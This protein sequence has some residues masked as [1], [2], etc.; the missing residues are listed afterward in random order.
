MRL[1]PAAR[2]LAVALLLP[3]LARPAAA[4]SYQGERDLGQRFDLAA[5][6]SVPLI[7][8]P[9]VIAYVTRIGQSVARTLTPSFFEYQF[10]VVRDPRI[11]AFAVP[12]GWVY[13]HA[14]LLAAVRSDDELAGVLGHEI[15]HVHNRHVVRQQEQTAALNYTAMLGMLLGVIQPAAGALTTAASQAAALQYQRD[16]EQ[17]ADYFGA[18]HVQEA[19]YDPRAMLDFFQQLA[20]QQRLSPT[21]APAYLQTHPLSDERLNRLE[22]VLKTSP[23]KRRQRPPASFDL[24]RVQALVRA[25]IEPAADVLAAY[26]RAL[27]QHPHDPTAQYLYGVVCLESGELD[28][29]QRSLSAARAGGLAAADRELG[30]L[31]LRQ[32]DPTR[33]RELLGAYLQRMPDDAGALLE[34]GKADEA[35]GDSAAAMDAYRRALAIAPWLATAQHGYGMLAG[36]AGREGEGFYHLATAARLSGDYPTALNQYRRAQP[37]LPTADP[38]SEDAQRWTETLSTYLKVE[39]PATPGGE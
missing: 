35:L 29:A 33:A 38:R 3:L 39:P 36:R 12:G 5:R 20:D 18:R 27:D 8:D 22:A 7:T 34:L 32:R 28:E 4:V 37:L 24:Q 11:N 2:L 19:G 23:G 31:A 26:R 16:F 14:G 9:E 1:M 6:Q 10:A 15:G 21:L 13:V 25:R 30:R 17:E